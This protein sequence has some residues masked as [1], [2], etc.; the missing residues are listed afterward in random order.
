MQKELEQSQRSY[1]KE[2]EN[3]RNE[4]T[5]VHSKYSNDKADWQKEVEEAAKK[6]L[7]LSEQLRFQSD[8][9][10]SVKKLQEEIQKIKLAFEDQILC[11]QKQLE[12]KDSQINELNDRLKETSRRLEESHILIDQSQKLH[13]VTEVKQ[14]ESAEQKEERQKWWQRLFK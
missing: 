8:S 12:I 3:L 1:G 5:T 6:Q 2:I 14:I 11:L 9:E 4:L 7:E 10:D 13:A